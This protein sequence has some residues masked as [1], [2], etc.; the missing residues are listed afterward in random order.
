MM[1]RLAG[2]D[3]KAMSDMVTESTVGCNAET[4]YSAVL[5]KHTF[6]EGRT[7]DTNA[8]RDGVS[9]VKPS[10]C[11]ERCYNEYLEKSTESW[12]VCSQSASADYEA[13]PVRNSIC[14]DFVPSCRAPS[15]C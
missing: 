4:F 15:V 2:G 6:K 10:A 8:K 11:L 14:I 9:T 13:R 5:S 7:L 3:S 12:D 1:Q